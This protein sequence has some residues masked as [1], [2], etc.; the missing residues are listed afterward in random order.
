MKED[1]PNEALK[2]AARLY[3]KWFRD[4]IVKERRDKINKIQDKLNDK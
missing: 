1:E 2:L 3:E 4:L